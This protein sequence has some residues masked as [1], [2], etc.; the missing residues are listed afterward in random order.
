MLRR[1]ASASW[2]CASVVSMDGRSVTRTRAPPGSAACASNW[3]S[4]GRKVPGT[5]AAARADNDRPLDRQISANEIAQRALAH[6]KVIPDLTAAAAFRRLREFS[7]RAD[8][9]S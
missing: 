3:I 4:C 6:D 9:P 5:R 1:C 8:W 2:D 7:V